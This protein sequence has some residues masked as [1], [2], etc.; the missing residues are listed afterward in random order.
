MGARVGLAAVGRAP[1][2]ARRRRRRSACRRRKA[3]RL[4]CVGGVL[5]DTEAAAQRAQA[6]IGAA[7]YSGSVSVD[8]PTVTVTVSAGSRLRVPLARVSRERST[9]PR[10]P[11]LS[12]V[13]PGTREADH[14][15]HQP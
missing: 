12:A 9:P 4:R 2:R 7:G 13:S 6:I 15:P 5:L 10:R 11:S 3:T 14:A 8:G 1:R